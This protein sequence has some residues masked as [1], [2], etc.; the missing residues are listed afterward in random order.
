MQHP[1]ALASF[2]IKQL[3]AHTSMRCRFLILGGQQRTKES[4]IESGAFRRHAAI[5]FNFL[6][7]TVLCGCDERWP[8][9]CAR[10]GAEQQPAPRG[11]VPAPGGV[12]ASREAAAAGAGAEI[13]QHRQAQPGGGGGGGRKVCRM[14]GWKENRGGSPIGQGKGGPTEGS[15]ARSTRA[16]SWYSLQPV[17]FDRACAPAHC[18]HAPAHWSCQA[19]VVPRV[20]DDRRAQAH[21]AAQEAH[22][23]TAARP[24]L[25]EPQQHSQYQQHPA[26]T[27]GGGLGSQPPFPFPPPP[28]RPQARLRPPHKIPKQKG[29]QANRMGQQRSSSCG[30]IPARETGSLN[31]VC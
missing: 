4:G 1:S 10:R 29:R 13:P 24:D 2:K 16:V 11:A 26:H 27:A 14:D 18:S 21:H 9:E 5:P 23:A 31:H 25:L 17:L 12:R 22:A 8:A 7:V 30:T 20:C 6:T 15:P 28:A 3:N 19:L